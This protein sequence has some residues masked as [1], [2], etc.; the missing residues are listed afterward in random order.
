[1]DI[2]CAYPGTFG[3]PH[4][5]HLR[6]VQRAALVYAKVLIVCS[7]NEDK[8]PWFTPEEVKR[9]WL[10]FDLP[11]NVEVITL[12]EFMA[13]VD[14]PK[15]IVMIRGVRN[16]DDVRHEQ[17][18]M[19]QNTR[20]FGLTMFTYIVSDCGYEKYS[21]S[22]VRQ[23]AIAGDLEELNRCVPQAV[24]QEVLDRLAERRTK[25]IPDDG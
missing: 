24:A 14:D 2:Y 16:E 5:G 21:S 18:V 6:L 20:D 17:G 19:L 25:G 12:A 1:M 7:V 15:N 9:L 3:P 10:A 4:N 8:H 23:A 22:R 11:E 13:R